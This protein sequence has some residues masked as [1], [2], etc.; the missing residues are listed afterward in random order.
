MT[1]PFFSISTIRYKLYNIL[2][3][4]YSTNDALTQTTATDQL[5]A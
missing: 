2:T 3:T 1:D 5:H 4:L